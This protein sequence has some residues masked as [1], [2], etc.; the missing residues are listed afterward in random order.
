MQF[1]ERALALADNVAMFFRSQWVVEG[2][3]R[4]EQIFRDHPPTLCAFFVERV[5]LCKGRWEPYGSTATAYSWLIWMKDRAPQAPFWIPPG[6]RETYMRDSDIKRF[7]NNES[8]SGDALTPT[9]ASSAPASS[10]PSPLSLNDAGAPLLKG[11]SDGERIPG[12]S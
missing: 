9:S 12:Q 10:S 4:Y 5:N 2:I 3:E 11:E 8:Q 7:G 6:C 1:V